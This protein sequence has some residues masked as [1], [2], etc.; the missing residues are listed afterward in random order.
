MGNRCAHSCCGLRIP[1]RWRE[2]T[3]KAILAIDRIVPVLWCSSTS[4][5]IW[6]LSNALL[7]DV[8]RRVTLDHCSMVYVRLPT[9]RPTISNTETPTISCDILDNRGSLNSTKVRLKPRNQQ[10][11]MLIGIALQLWVRTLFF[12]QSDHWNRIL[13]AAFWPRSHISVFDS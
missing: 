5:L 12:Q 3:S 6:W 7:L 8:F 13:V 10:G 9:A 1:A 11:Q 4:L 2:Q